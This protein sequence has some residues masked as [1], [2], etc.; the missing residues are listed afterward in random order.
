VS[1]PR[2]PSEHPFDWELLRASIRRRIAHHLHGWAAEEIDDATQ[3][4]VVKL[5]RFLERSGTPSNLDGLLTVIARRT[6]VER[7]R[8]HSRR[9]PLEALREDST[10]TFDEA[11]RHDLA[12]LEDLVAWKA[13]QVTEFFRANQASCLELAQARA[14]GVGLHRIAEETNQSHDALLQ[15]WSRCMRRLRAAIASGELAWERPEEDA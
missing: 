13:F 4:V 8:A 6:A 11:S 5:L 14:R 12:R 2:D 3:D 9:P 15:R 7:I 10:V 1:P